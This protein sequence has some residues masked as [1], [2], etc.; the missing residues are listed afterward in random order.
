MDIKDLRIELDS[1]NRQMAELL[2][3]RLLIS[4][5]VALYKKE[6]GLPI[7]DEK[8]EQQ[9]IKEVKEI[10][11]EEFSEEAKELFTLLMKQSRTLQEKV[12]K[13]E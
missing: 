8:R 1:I 5:E 13:E 11:G 6:K 9:I 4:R 7:P 10:A 3:R 2:K 12:N